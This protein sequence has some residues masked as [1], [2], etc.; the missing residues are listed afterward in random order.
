MQRRLRWIAALRLVVALVACAQLGGVRP[1]HSAE[2]APDAAPW[3]VKPPPAEQLNQA[4]DDPRVG[5]AN[6]LRFGLKALFPKW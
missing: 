3:K 4:A 2:A 1:I 6:T 5:P